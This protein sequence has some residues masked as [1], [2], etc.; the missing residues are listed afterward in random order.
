MINKTAKHQID[1]L[2]NIIENTHNPPQTELKP[3]QTHFLLYIKPAM[4]YMLTS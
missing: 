2:S 3:P 1:E 4:S